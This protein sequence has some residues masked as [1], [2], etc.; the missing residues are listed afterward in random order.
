MLYRDRFKKM[1][2]LDGDLCWKFRECD[3][4]LRTGETV[5][6]YKSIDFNMKVIY[7]KSLGVNLC[8]QL[9]CKLTIALMKNFCGY[10][11]VSLETELK[12]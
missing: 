2:E 1:G 4:F 5:I 7:T 10:L 6:E 11:I 3:R 8:E 9:P 12:F